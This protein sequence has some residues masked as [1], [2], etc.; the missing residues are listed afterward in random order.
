MVV[1]T[2]DCTSLND[3]ELAEMADLC[4]ER[5]PSFDIGFLSKQRE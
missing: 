2:K 4:A 1:T 3:T 5:T